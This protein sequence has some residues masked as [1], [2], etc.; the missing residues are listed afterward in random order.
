MSH[1]TTEQLIEIL[2]RPNDTI[3]NYNIITRRLM[4]KYSEDR[5]ALA[6]IFRANSDNVD[7]DTASSDSKWPTRALYK[8]RDHLDWDLVSKY[9]EKEQVSELKRHPILKKKLKYEM[10]C[11]R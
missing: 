2:T 1:L 8:M 10:I 4:N 7:W 5:W 9:L 11:N 3:Y 6:L